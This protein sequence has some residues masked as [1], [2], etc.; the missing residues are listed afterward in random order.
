[1]E[2]V[3]PKAIM[4]LTTGI[5][6]Y[7]TLL[8]AVKLGVF[9]TVVNNKS[10][11]DI[12]KQINSNPEYTEKLLDALVA[13]KFLIKEMDEYKNAPVSEKFL[14]K[15]SKSYYGDFVVLYEASL[16]SGWLDLDKVISNKIARTNTEILSDPVFTRA[17]HN[18]AIAPA[19]V[20]ANLIDFSDKKHLLDIGGG[21]G[22]YSIILADK[23]KNL[24][25]TVVEQPVAADTAQ[26]YAPLQSGAH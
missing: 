12:S 1:M 23:F 8:A 6:E 14:V 10:V 13:M 15:T 7:M 21:S 20:L 24:K 17:M 5:W 26:E 22:A 11:Q 18:N 9:D 4:R 16:K 3:T 25:S 2:K 19:N